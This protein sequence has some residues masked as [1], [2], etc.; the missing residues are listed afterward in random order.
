VYPSRSADK[1]KVKTEPCPTLTILTLTILMVPTRLDSHFHYRQAY[2]GALDAIP[3]I[4]SSIEFF[5]DV[6]D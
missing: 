4:F 5:E 3:L 2:A 6:L 1:V